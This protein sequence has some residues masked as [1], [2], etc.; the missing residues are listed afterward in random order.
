M[1]GGTLDP[2]GFLE[3]VGILVLA[4]H[5]APVSSHPVLQYLPMTRMPTNSLAARTRPLPSASGRTRGR[6][7]APGRDS[8]T[9]R[10]RLAGLG[11]ELADSLAP[12]VAALPGSGEGPQ[13]LAAALGLDKVL[14][15]RLL[16]ALR[17]PDPLAVVHHAPGPAPLRRL[18]EAARRRGVAAGPLARARRAVDDF[19]ALLKGEVGD[20]S[21]L[22]AILSAWLPEARGEFELRRKQAAFKAMSQLKGASCEHN[23]ATV[24][25]HP[26]SSGE[27]IDVLWIMGLLGIQ[28]L[29]PGV[30][31]KLAT[32]RMVADDEARHPLDLCGRRIEAGDIPSLESFCV[33]PPARAL[34]ECVG[35]VVHY[36]L[37]GDEF[38]Q[39]SSV[40]HL[41]AELN[42]EEMPGAVRR[43]SGR[44]GHVFAE[45]PV[46]ARRLTFDVFVHADVYPGAE[47]ELFVY[48][49]ALGGVAD[50][51]DRARDLD[52]LEVSERIELLGRGLG[53]AALDGFPDYRRL[54]EHALDSAN[55]RAE[56]LR[57]Y[58]V[59]LDFPI[60]GS[61][62]LLAFQPPEAA[63]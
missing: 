59:A 15:S 10:E 41:T 5:T 39:H 44:R 43:D 18:L 24:L 57:G 8:S 62:V 34:V 21:A 35:G 52:R 9:L 19:E 55:W 17:Q 7:A 25:L 61:Q 12:V 4:A 14:T 22:G 13:R 42:L 20:R 53:C 36:I 28:R 3:T 45:V 40:D 38:G 50:V 33:A 37:R 47:P 23:L 60:Y 11:R 63:R 49:T 26:S 32:R 51:N 48:D 16:K 30:S 1:P 58:R 54:L 27:R 29:R 46:P 2:G 6:A 31:I 56:S